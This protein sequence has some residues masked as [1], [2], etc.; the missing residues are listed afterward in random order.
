MNGPD[1]LVSE[2]SRRLGA[3]MAEVQTRPVDRQRR[4][5]VRFAPL[6]HI[7]IMLEP[8][9][10]RHPC[11]SLQGY[12]VDLCEQGLRVALDCP[13]DPGVLTRLTVIIADTEPALSLLGQVTHCTP[14]V[15]GREY[16]V[17][18]SLTDD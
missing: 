11:F 7:A 12:L 13:L 6:Q 4:V 15:T 14:L 3:H 10:P 2:V 18:L 9:N 16:A 8:A 17:G 5:A 1:L